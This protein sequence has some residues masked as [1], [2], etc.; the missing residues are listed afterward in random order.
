MKKFFKKAAIFIGGLFLVT[1]I[2]IALFMNMSPQFGGIV[3]KE[4][5]REF[6]KLDHYN[7]GKFLNFEPI[8]MNFDFDNISKIVQQLLNPVAN[9]KPKNNITVTKFD[10]T[11]L[12]NQTIG[13][14]RVTWLGHSSF[15]IEIEGKT[16][17]LDP[18]FSEYASPLDISSAKRFINTMPFKLEDLKTIDAV[19]IS[20][21]HYDHLDYKTILKIKDKVKHVFT[22]L[23]VG[24]HFKT[25]EVDAS[26][27]QELDWWQ[28]TNLGTIKLVCTPARHM[29]GRGLLDQSSTLWS[30]WCILGK[31]QKLY[32]SGD[33]GYGN[34]F[35]EIGEK[36]GP[37]DLAMLECGQYDEKWA[38]I[39]M[40]PEET[41][42]A[43]IDVKATTMMPI[44]W[45][46]FKLAN[47]TWTDPV[48]RFV[49]K[50]TE[51]K[52]NYVTPKIGQSI[53]LTSDNYPQKKWWENL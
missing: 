42:Q 12:H 47:H 41:V 6:E 32:F 16:I 23:G 33:G 13:K 39:H 28:E 20:H 8:K 52:T 51:L 4:Q 10:L 5:Q 49:K 25:W 50:S 18:V 45:G 36:Y 2:A 31:N 21:D 44:H 14:T 48:E 27:I 24:N 9:T 3:S 37:F 1:F 22:P 40:I 7:D 30:S 34:H 11:T 46:A 35:S 38:G 53:T 17:L 15:L 26:K 43:G 29:S 19:I